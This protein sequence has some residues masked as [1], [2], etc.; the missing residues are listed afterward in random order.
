MDYSDSFIIL[1][2]GLVVIALVGLAWVLRKRNVES[3]LLVFGNPEEW[4]R[5]ETNR[6]HFRPHLPKLEKV[7]NHILGSPLGSDLVEDKVIHGLSLLC[8]E[9]FEEIV[10]L[11][12]NG[13]GFGCHKLLRGMWER[14]VVAAHLDKNPGDAQRFVDWH[15]MQH[16]KQ[17]VSMQQ[18]LE[19]SLIP[20]QVLEEIT[21]RRDAV[22]GK[23]VRECSQ[24][25]CDKVIPAFSWTN[26]SMEAMARKSAPELLSISTLC[27]DFALSETHASAGAIGGRMDEMGFANRNEKA[28]EKVDACLMLAHQLA[29]RMFQLQLKRREFLKAEMEKP[30]DALVGEYNII[31]K[32]APEHHHE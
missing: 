25:D 3:D 17:M 16:Y 1:A 6:P 22:K 30:L 12:G 9:D 32:A 20:K 21:N 8:W 14:A 26:L 7:A 23:F 5:F 31:W 2:I 28:R 29:L 4:R 15:P 18:H 11:A 13:F 10:C 24:K 27:Y 19:P